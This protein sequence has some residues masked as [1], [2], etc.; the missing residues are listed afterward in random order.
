MNAVVLLSIIL[1]AI[2]RRNIA[3]LYAFFF[4]LL[5]FHEFIKQTLMNF[6]GSV[7]VFPIWR[8][9][10]IL[11][12]LY[13][14]LL[15]KKKVVFNNVVKLFFYILF[16]TFLFFLTIG[17]S[18]NKESAVSI[19]RLELMSMALMYSLSVIRITKD[20]V[21]VVMSGMAISMFL[22]CV[23]GFV[24]RFFLY[25]PIHLFMG[26]FERGGGFITS[27]FEI[28]GIQRMCGIMS[29]PNQFGVTMGLWIPL[30]YG[31]YQ[32]LS[33]FHNK[34]MLLLL[35][36]MLTCL[37]LSFSRA[38]WFLCFGS[39]LYYIV[40]TNKHF[41]KYLLGLFMV[42]ALIIGIVSLLVPEVQE[43]IRDSLSGKE[44]S[45]GTR[46]EFLEL[47]YAEILRDPVAHGL[48]SGR[49][50][51]KTFTESA[52]LIMLY[53]IGFAGVLIFL[54]FYVTI[55]INARNK[56]SLGLLMP[57][58]IVILSIIVWVVSVNFDEAPFMMFLW[59][60]MGVSI[61]KSIK[62]ITLRNE[63]FSNSYT[64]L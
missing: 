8:E 53:E 61:N 36:L 45:A 19:I 18:V 54:L 12:I 26:N 64:S 24:E 30:F 59:G 14:C 29:G 2:T 56:N 57:S 33:Q 22:L 27:S 20:D 44:S 50:D 11:L 15:L 3:S 60:L 40:K 10:L 63:K 39:I 21:S 7:G 42:G 4:A 58:I 32:R 1:F 48:G 49:I 43:I 52:A 9:I 5:P 38:G 62:Q 25:F 16:I 47:G 46:R 23:S 37:I 35:C 41:I 17:L 6:S 34:Y 51:G 13:R 31:A 28:S 55:I